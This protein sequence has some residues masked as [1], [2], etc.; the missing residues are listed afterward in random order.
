M[1]KGKRQDGKIGKVKKIVHS[2]K[3]KIKERIGFPYILL[4][5]I[6]A[7]IIGLFVLGIKIPFGEENSSIVDSKIVKFL[8]LYYGMIN[9]TVNNKTLENGVWKININGYTSDGIVNFDIQMNANDFTI[10]KIS[11]NLVIPSKPTTIREIGREIGCSVGGKKTVDIYIDPYDPWS[12]RYDGEIDNF[13]SKFSDSI[14]PT[15]RIL[16]TY[17]YKYVYQDPNSNAYLALLYYECTKNE[18]YFKTFKSCVISKYGEK[19]DFLTDAELKECVRQSNGKVENIEKCVADSY[20]MGE[21][22]TDQRFAE[23]FIGTATTPM[24]VV[25]CKYVIYPL[26]MENAFCYLYPEIEKCKE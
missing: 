13:L 19:K 26:Y 20:P 5:S 18:D 2:V 25:D 4:F 21:L 10:T 6:V 3:E 24:Y 8:N 17:T 7:I 16:S 12:I 14:R 9:I 23:T 15:Y 1:A 11:Q 22:R